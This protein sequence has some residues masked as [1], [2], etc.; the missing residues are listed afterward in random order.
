MVQLIQKWPG[1]EEARL[2]A[3]PSELFYHLFYICFLCLLWLLFLCGAREGMQGNFVTAG[4]LAYMEA[5]R[6]LYEVGANHTPFSLML[7]IGPRV[8]CLLGKCSTDQATFQPHLLP[9]TKQNYSYRLTS[10][11]LKK[12]RGYLISIWSQRN[13][14]PLLSLAWLRSCASPTDTIFLFVCTYIFDIYRDYHFCVVLE[15][16]CRTSHLYVFCHWATS[17]AP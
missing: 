13:L 5:S 15:M 17:L 8:V 14:W 6:E 10:L 1:P 11:V 7:G 16:G 4:V 3:S 9:I 2:C 12:Q